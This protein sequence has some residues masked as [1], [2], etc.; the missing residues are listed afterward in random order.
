MRW[1]H[2]AAFG[3]GGS[4]KRGLLAQGTGTDSV[5]SFRIVGQCNRVLDPGKQTFLSGKLLRV[6]INGQWGLR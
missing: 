2:A 4:R 5:A 3:V 1:G 6:G